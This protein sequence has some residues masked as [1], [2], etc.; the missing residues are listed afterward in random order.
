MLD[1][2]DRIFQHLKKKKKKK[3]K[4]TPKLSLQDLLFC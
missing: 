1:I 3:K 4:L 2:F